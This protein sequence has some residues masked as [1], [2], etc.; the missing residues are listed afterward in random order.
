MKSLLDD[1][2]TRIFKT[3]RKIKRWVKNE[4]AFILL[5]SGASLLV[6]NIFELSMKFK[7]HMPMLF[8]W[9]LVME[10]MVLCMVLVEILSRIKYRKSEGW[11]NYDWP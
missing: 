8:V 11:A 3:W 9:V 10:T 6:F 7:T 4:Y 2:K 1:L 5:I